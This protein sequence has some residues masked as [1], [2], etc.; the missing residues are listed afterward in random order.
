MT[1]PG[2]PLT[3]RVMA[4]RIWQFHFGAAIVATPSDFGSRGRQPNNPAL[5]DHLASR[6][7]AS[8]WSIK[9]MHR[10][11]MLSH[12]WQLT[13]VEDPGSAAHDA[14]ND[15]LWHFPRRRLEAEEIRDAILT[16]S[17]RLDVA[18]PAAHPFPPAHTW[19][20]TQHSQ[21]SA[22]YDSL[23]RSVYVMQQRI[24]KH[25]FFAIFDGA[26]TGASTPERMVSTSPLQALFLMNDPFVFSQAD[27]FA[28][29]LLGTPDLRQEIDAAYRL[30]LAR[31]ATDRELDAA[32]AYIAHYRQLSSETDPAKAALSS[33]V[34]ALIAS[35]EFMYVD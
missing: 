28:Q 27:A 6:F 9:A 29:R 3:A 21:F 23:H 12:A 14:V 20:F 17:G 15:T 26:D 25:P 33:F 5:L 11:I 24:R 10:A 7:I 31:H 18:I 4:N 30:A 34:R 16:V 8:G 1:S 2:N 32:L 13:S 35:N 19:E 22:V